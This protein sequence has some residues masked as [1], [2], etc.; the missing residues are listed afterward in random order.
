MNYRA[1]HDLAGTIDSLFIYPV[2]S[3][4]GIAV[5][6]ARLTATGLEWDRHW[7][8]TDPQGRFITQREYPRMALIRPALQTGELILNAPGMAQLH[9]PT[10]VEPGRETATPA[11]TV[12]VWKDTVAAL[13]QGDA[14]ARWFSQFLEAPC[15]LVRFDPRFRRMVD[16]KWTDG[17]ESITQ[18]ADGFPLLITSTASVQEINQRLDAQGQASIDVRRFRPNLVLSGID[19]H[20]EDRIDTLFIDT[21]WQEA[22]LRPTK[23]CS[24][25]PIP[26]I[27]PD[28]AEQGTAVNATLRTYRQD[29]RV[30]G[31]LTFGM[32]AIPVAGEGVVLRAGQR[33]A[34][35]LRFD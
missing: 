32:N 29:P 4:A 8:V 9:V 24:R 16:G 23:P 33:I 11:A 3:C 22:E 7:M 30:G 6:E 25:C 27:H 34:A 10:A 31:A 15:R 28:T 26:D 19:A 17:M 21:E 35:N 20:D 18:F 2:K 5:R 1:D 12:T 13:D 14:A